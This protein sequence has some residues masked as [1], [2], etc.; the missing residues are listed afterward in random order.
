MS[1][2]NTLCKQYKETRG[3]FNQVV[4]EYLRWLQM[5]LLNQTEHTDDLYKKLGFSKYQYLFNF[6]KN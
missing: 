3:N 1:R 6:R 4:G 2:F 5:T